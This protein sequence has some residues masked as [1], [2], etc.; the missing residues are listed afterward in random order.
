MAMAA[1][2]AANLFNGLETRSWNWWVLGG[3]LLGPVLIT[4]YTAV[5]SAFTPSFIWTYVYGNNVFLWPSAYFWLTMLFTILLSLFP[6]YMYRYYQENY[7]PDDINVLAWLSKA[8][9]TW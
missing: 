8:D 6:R 5:Y 3:V 4:G 9:P 1:V 7:Y 2:Y